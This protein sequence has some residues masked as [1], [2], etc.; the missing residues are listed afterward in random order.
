[1]KHSDAPNGVCSTNIAFN[2]AFELVDET[3]HNLEFTSGCSG[4][5][6]AI[7]KLV[8]GMEVSRVVALLAG[9]TCGYKQTSYAD[10]L[11]RSV[12]AAQRV[13]SRG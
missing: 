10:Q 2:I 3:V 9:N 8:E 7:A 5:L 4:N 1:M 6:L 13:E 12:L 11:T